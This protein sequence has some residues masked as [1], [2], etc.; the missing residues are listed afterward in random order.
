MAPEHLQILGRKSHAEALA[1]LERWDIGV[2][3]FS[4][5]ENFYFSPLK[6]FEYMAAEL[7]TVASNVGELRAILDDGRAGVLVAPDD[8]DALAAA[9]VE[10]DRDRVRVRELGRAALEFARR[11][12]TWT[13]NATRVLTTLAGVGTR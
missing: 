7:C 6:L 11:Q 1:L 10:L 4:D 12:P 3:P 9:L 13:D 2:A 8:P 5:L